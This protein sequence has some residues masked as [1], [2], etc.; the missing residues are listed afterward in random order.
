MSKHTILVAVTVETH[1]RAQ[2]HDRL[3]R[4]LPRP[5]GVPW[6]ESWWV[7]EDDRRDGSDN[8]SAVFVERGSQHRAHVELVKAGLTAEHNRPDHQVNRGCHACAAGLHDTPMRPGPCL[9]CGA[10][11]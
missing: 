5:G 6:L 1:D 7:A 8:D 9:C 3:M 4:I 11:L 2:A 10:P